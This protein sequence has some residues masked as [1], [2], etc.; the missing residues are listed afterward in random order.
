MTAT[1]ALSTIGKIREKAR[2]DEQGVLDQLSE[3]D[4]VRVMQFLGDDK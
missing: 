3:E 4:A 2:T 1:K